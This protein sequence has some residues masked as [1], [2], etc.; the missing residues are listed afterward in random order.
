VE[1]IFTR[2][3]PSGRMSRTSTSSRCIFF[4]IIG[5]GGQRGAGGPS[6]EVRGVG[7]EGQSVVLE[8][9]LIG[10]VG[11][12]GSPNEYDISDVVL[13]IVSTSLR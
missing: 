7:D 6:V 3:R 2:F 4:G 8:A 13:K 5:L 10:G 12:R 9:G 1:G 11:N